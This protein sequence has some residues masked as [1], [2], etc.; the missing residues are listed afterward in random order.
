MNRSVTYFFL[1][2]FVISLAG[3]GCKKPVENNNNQDSEPKEAKQ[4]LEKKR[5][6]VESGHVQYVFEGMKTGTEDL[7]F[8]DWGWKE[9]AISKSKISIAPTEENTLRLLDGFIQYSV[10]LN[11]NVAT[12]IDNAILKQIAEK[13]T[14]DSLTGL[15]EKMLEQAGAVKKG[16]KI[17]A[18]Q[19]CDIW[20]VPN[21]GTTQ[22]VYKGVT[23]EINTNFAGINYVQRATS[24]E[25]NIAVDA[26][27]FELPEGVE[28][29]EPVDL[30]KLLKNL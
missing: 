1:S 7:Y 18:G 6:D 20:E 19:E 5:Y 8:D 27:K 23:L 14:E 2:L 13:N 25:F 22:C 24:I 9:S 12:K 16:T 4:L 3:A 21:L 28:I 29:S 17:V 11:T 30:Q 26:N 15:G 10:D